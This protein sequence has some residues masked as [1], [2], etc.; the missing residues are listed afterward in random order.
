MRNLDNK[1][2]IDGYNKM[3]NSSI[4]ICSIVRDCE[5]SLKRNIY[6]IE[7]IRKS[8]SKAT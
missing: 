4:S 6:V 1:I 2:L 3:S 8:F 7:A 5:E